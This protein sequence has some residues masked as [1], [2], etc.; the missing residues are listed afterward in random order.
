MVVIPFRTIF[1]GM[2]ALSP[3][4]VSSYHKRDCL[5]I[6]HRMG[7]GFLDT[8]HLLYHLIMLSHRMPGYPG[9]FGDGTVIGLVWAKPHVLPDLPLLLGEFLRR[10]D[11][12]QPVLNGLP[13]GV[14]LL[15]EHFQFLLT[16]LPGVGVDAFGVLGAVRPGGR[17]AALE[18]VVVDLGDAAGSGLSGAP[19]D[20][21]EVSERI[22]L[23]RVLRYLIAQSPVDLGGGLAKHVAGDV[24]VNVQGG[25]R[26]HM[27]Q[28]G[29]EGLDVHAVL[30]RHG[31]K[32]V[33]LWHNKD[34]SESP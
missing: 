31:G 9:P 24:G 2:A 26:R 18:E 13:L 34:K 12:S 15:D 10:G 6:E 16:L 30:Q 8:Q 11:P 4:L 28:H 5:A 17:V 23:R 14:Q 32:G 20:R 22:C 27:A 25:G 3:I 29:G 33:P 1:R 7:S 21:L 19:H